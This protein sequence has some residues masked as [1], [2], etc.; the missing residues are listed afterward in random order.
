[1]VPVCAGL[2]GIWGKTAWLDFVSDTLFD[3]ALRSSRDVELVEAMVEAGAGSESPNA[4]QETAIY[5]AANL[6]LDR[7]VARLIDSGADVNRK[8]GR[9]A[10]APLGWA[11][12]GRFH[13]PAA[14]HRRH[15]EVVA[16]LVAAGATVEGRWLADE[17]VRA[18]GDLFAV[19]STPPNAVPVV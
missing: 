4:L 15:R 5:W 19:L 8:D 7:L 18:D 14:S 10:S 13:A 9:Y 1:M 12:Q 3:G 17:K 2:T 16:L 11:I 6:G